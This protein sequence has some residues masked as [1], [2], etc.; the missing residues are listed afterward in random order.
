M[1]YEWD[2]GGCALKSSIY[3]I[4]LRNI[5]ISF[6]SV[7]KM[8]Y[9]RLSDLGFSLIEYIVDK[10]TRESFILKKYQ[11]FPG[12]SMVRNL[13]ACRGQGFDLL[14]GKIP[15]AKGQLS[16]PYSTTAEPMCSRPCSAMR[17]ATTMRSLHTA[18]RE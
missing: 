11:D 1:V 14:C 4:E 12:G 5:A 9:Y 2:F 8:I 13:P 18:A 3:L 10:Y 7:F 15:R 16:C 17:Q 6:V